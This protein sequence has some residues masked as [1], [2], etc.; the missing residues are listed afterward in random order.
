MATVTEQDLRTYCELDEQRKQFQRQ[1]DA[2]ERQMTPTKDR[3]KAHLSESDKPSIRRGEYTATLTDGRPIV[4]WKD[5][6]I[7][8]SDAETAAR[9]QEAAPKGKTLTVRKDDA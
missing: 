6:F 1:A 9:I 7:L 3:I 2:V 5:Q 4:N 8:V